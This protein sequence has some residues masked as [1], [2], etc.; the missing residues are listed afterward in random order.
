LGIIIAGLVVITMLLAASGVMFSTFLNSSVSGAQSLK[1]LNR[2]NVQRHG[3]ALNITN[4]AF[5]GSESKDLIIS[6]DNTGSQSVARFGDMDVI[7]E[8]TDS[9][10]KSVLTRLQYTDAAIGN[11]QWTV[12]ATGVQPDSFNPR[13][14]DSDESLYIDLRVNPAVKSGTS[15]LIVVGTP[16]AVADQSTVDAP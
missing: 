13:F 9:S 3:S 6:V 14:W 1:D 7:V 11:N 8:Y 4:G 16:W 10:D 5:D 15:V 2:A 12:S